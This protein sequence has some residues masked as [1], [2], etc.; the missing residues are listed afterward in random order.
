MNLFWI[1]YYILLILIC[2]FFTKFN[3]NK[4]INFF[5]IPIIFGV[6]GAIWFST[7]GDSELAPIISIIF[8][9]L[10]IID[11]NGLERLLRPMIAFVVFFQ[12]LSLIYYFYKKKFLKR[13]SICY[14]FSRSKSPI[15]FL[16]SKK[17]AHSPGLK[18]SELLII[19]DLYL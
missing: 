15:L 11:S 3:K 12:I 8:L 17:P 1:F 7:P 6:F 18:I 2:Y 9:E 13:N 4:F 16:P 14:F 19:S 10:S 5:F